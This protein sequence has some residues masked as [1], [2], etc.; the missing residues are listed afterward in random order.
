MVGEIFVQHC[1]KVVQEVN[2]LITEVIKIA[3]T[4]PYRVTDLSSGGIILDESASKA[5][6]N[7]LFTIFSPLRIAISSKLP[8]HKELKF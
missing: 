4:T 5:V 6:M 3:Q 8:G 2:N 1:E 7:S